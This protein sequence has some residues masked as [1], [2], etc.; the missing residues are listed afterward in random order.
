MGGTYGVFRVMHWWAIAM[1]NDA[2]QVQHGSMVDGKHT[3]D[4]YQ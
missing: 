3:I 1:R 4:G 2:K